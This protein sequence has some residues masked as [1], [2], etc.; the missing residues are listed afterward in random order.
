MDQHKLNDHLAGL[1]LGDLRYFD[2]IGSTNDVAAQWLKAGCPNLALVVADEQTA[3]RGRS[4]R[5]W[6]TPAGSALALSLVLIA[7]KQFEHLLQEQN[8]AR[9]NG[10]GALAVCQALHRN[11]ALP[12]KI[13]WPNDIIV[14]GKKLAGILAETHWLG[15]QLLGVIL[16]VG[17]NVST[18]SI[19]PDKWDSLNP[20]PYPATSMESALGTPVKRWEL[21]YAVLQELLNWQ[22]QLSSDAFL[23]TWEAYLAFRGQSVQIFQTSQKDHIYTG[24]ILGLAKDGGLNIKTDNGQDHCLR[25][26]I[27]LAPDSSPDDFHLRPVD[28]SQK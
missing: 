1:H 9:L 17:I 2:S 18:T 12:A 24:K 14:K 6:F 27:I 26:G 22:K 19:P 7:D 25:S 3:G 5:K 10:L 11:Y 28:S 4:E 8:T 15:N 16:G 21:L 20:H 13:K 23:E